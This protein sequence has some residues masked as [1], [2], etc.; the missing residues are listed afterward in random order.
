MDPELRCFFRPESGEHPDTAADLVSG[1]HGNDL[2]SELKLNRILVLGSIGM[3]LTC[4]SIEVGKDSYL[5]RD[6][7]GNS[8]E[9]PKSRCQT[10]SEPGSSHVALKSWSLGAKLDCI[11]E[12]H[13]RS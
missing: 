11:S 3:N 7:S 2:A 10:W 4:T 13:H 5:F 6:L 12:L 8:R 9:E 1:V